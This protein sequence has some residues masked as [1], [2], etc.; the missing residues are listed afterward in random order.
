M[1]KGEG[2]KK[3]K[4]NTDSKTW[5]SE[6]KT[7]PGERSQ[8]LLKIILLL[9]LMWR[10]KSY[11]ESEEQEVT[12]YSRFNH[13]CSWFSTKWQ[14]KNAPVEESSSFGLDFVALKI[15]K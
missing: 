4:S 1:R 12:A 10:Q 2:G 3:R 13:L 5:D 7:E 9:E 15:A 8:T 14:K 6:K 11:R